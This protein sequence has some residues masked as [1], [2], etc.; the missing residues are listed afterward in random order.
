[1]GLRIPTGKGLREEG[2]DG[3]AAFFGP[4]CISAEESAML[5]IILIIYGTE[6]VQ[7]DWR[8]VF[9]IG[10]LRPGSNMKMKGIAQ[11]KTAN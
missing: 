3:D 9:L 7:V 8:G 5:Q 10:I 1:M 6:Q 2:Q 11:K 4:L